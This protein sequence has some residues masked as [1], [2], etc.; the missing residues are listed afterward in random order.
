MGEWSWKPTEEKLWY[1]KICGCYTAH[2][3][4]ASEPRTTHQGIRMRLEAHHLRTVD[5]VRPSSQGDLCLFKE[6]KPQISNIMKLYRTEEG[7]EE[8]AKLRDNRGK[9]NPK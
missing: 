6:L 3:E 7:L 2:P 1:S 8:R 9:E 5:I 4:T